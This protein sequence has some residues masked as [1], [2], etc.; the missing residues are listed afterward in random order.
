[1]L[2]Q[3]VI[4]AVFQLAGEIL[5]AATGILVP[6]PLIGLLLMLGWLHARGGPSEE[7]TATATTL[8]DHLGLYF[9]PAGVG[10]ITYGAVIARDGVAV[11]VAI[12]VSVVLSIVFTALIAAFPWSDLASRSDD[13]PAEGD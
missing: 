11:A 5:V 3:F 12:L 10:I 8:V 4:L 6:G 1:V 13:V 9:V 2:K 7:L